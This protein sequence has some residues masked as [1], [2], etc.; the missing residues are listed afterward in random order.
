MINVT[1]S[2]PDG[3]IA[4][5]QVVD[6]LPAGLSFVSGAGTGWTFSVSGSTVTMTYDGTVHNGP[7]PAATVTV[8]ID[9]STASPVVNTVTVST[10]IFDQDTSNN[11]S[12]ISTTVN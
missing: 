8:Q 4:P 7:L 9:P 1:N 12:T 10:N 6:T 11:T 5:V 2:G 3:T